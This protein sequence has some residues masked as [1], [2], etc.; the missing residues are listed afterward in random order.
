MKVASMKVASMEARM[1]E[2]QQF[3]NKI[4]DIESV[5]AFVIGK[6]EQKTWSTAKSKELKKIK[7]ELAS[8]LATMK[9]AKTSKATRAQVRVA[10]DTR[11][12]K[13]KE[14]DIPV[15]FLR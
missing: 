14:Q 11:E 5:L 3:V 2:D 10:R 4:Y 12:Q 7:S 8:K 1:K 6:L 9:W 13:T 15:E